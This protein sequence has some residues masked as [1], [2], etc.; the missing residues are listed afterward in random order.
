MTGIAL[1]DDLLLRTLRARADHGVEADRLIDDIG[2]EIARTGQASRRR[3]TAIGRRWGW[4]AATAVGAIATTVAV[5]TVGLSRSPAIRD[6]PVG[7]SGAPVSALAAARYQTAAF[8]PTM[9]FDVPDGTWT[10]TADLP[11][12][13]QLRLLRPDAPN[14]DNGSLTVLRLD[15]VTAGGPCGYDGSTSWPAGARQPP[16]FISWLQDRLP[17]GLDA[18]RPVTVLGHEALEVD[19]TAETALRQECDFGLLLSSTG[20]SESPRYAEIPVD[21]RRVRLVAVADS[22]ELFVLITEGG[23]TNRY[24]EAIQKAD[25]VIDTIALP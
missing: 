18:A 5:L 24:D 10:A 6:L 21:G 13:V 12:E 17:H 25:A 7:A 2:R 16:A 14:E 3:T 23:W 4:L 8:N 22:G 15:N 19:F 9:A 11:A 1:N 20:T